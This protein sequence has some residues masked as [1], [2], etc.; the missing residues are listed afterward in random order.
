MTGTS[1]LCLVL[2]TS[3]KITLNPKPE[4]LNS[5]PYIGTITEAARRVYWVRRRVAV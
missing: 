2:Q 5:K 1:Y 3:K 4:T